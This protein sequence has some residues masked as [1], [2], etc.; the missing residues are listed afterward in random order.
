MKAEIY[1][2]LFEKL[3]SLWAIRDDTTNWCRVKVYLSDYYRTWTILD[4]V[5]WRYRV[6]PDDYNY[7]TSDFE[8]YDLTIIWH[9]PILTDCIQAIFEINHIDTA[10]QK[11]EIWKLAFNYDYSRPYLK[12]QLDD[13][14]I[15]LLSLLSE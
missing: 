12:D 6:K 14:W 11:R 3:E 8:S 5:N 1:N 15:K 13:L 10:T 4:E 2:E 7:Q 9:E